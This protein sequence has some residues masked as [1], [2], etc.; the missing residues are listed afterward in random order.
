[1]GSM[2]SA[3][4]RAEDLTRDYR[5]EGNELSPALTA[6]D[7][8]HMGRWHAFAHIQRAGS[9]RQDIITITHDYS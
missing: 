1:M 7:M 2:Q 9:M 6:S 4:W 3:H 5:K 8:I